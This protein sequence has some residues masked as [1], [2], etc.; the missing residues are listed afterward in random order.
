VLVAYDAGTLSLLYH[1]E[2]V[3]SRD[4]AGPPVKFTTPTVANGKVY[5]GTQT[6]LDVYGLL[7]P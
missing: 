5:V 1:S 3:S 4:Q 6:E 2:M 7:G